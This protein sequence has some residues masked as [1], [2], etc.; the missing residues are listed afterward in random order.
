LFEISADP[1]EGWRSIFVEVYVDTL[2]G[3][4]G[5]R[6]VM[7]RG[8]LGYHYGPY[9]QTTEKEKLTVGAGA[10][11]TLSVV[12]GRVKFSLVISGATSTCKVDGSFKVTGRNYSVTKL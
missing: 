12:N 6:P 10:D 5:N 9:W 8:F 3:G 7:W 11:I 2:V 1:D 4:V